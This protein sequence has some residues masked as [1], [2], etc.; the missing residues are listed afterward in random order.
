M[1]Q[2]IFIMGTLCLF[3]QAK[4][5]S[6][7]QGHPLSIGDHVPN[8][9]FQNLIN[10][11]SKTVG[12]FDFK[13]KLLIIDFWAT[14]CSPCVAMIPKMDSL[15]EQFKDQIRFLSV[16]SQSDKEVRAFLERRKKFNL[17]AHENVQIV[18][19]TE[20]KKWFPHAT[21]PHYVW[22]NGEGIVSA[23]TGYEEVN[24]Q[25]IKN[26]LHQ[27]TSGLTVKK[28]VRAPYEA[29]LPLFLGG[30]GGTPN[31]LFYHSILTGYSET[32][33]AG[34]YTPKPDSSKTIR[35]RAINLQFI[36]LWRLAMRGIGRFNPNRVEVR[37]K[38][39]LQLVYNFKGSDIEWYRA[40][41]YC[42]DLVLPQNMA[43]N[44]YAF[45]RT[46]LERLFPRYIVKI[47]Q[48]TRKYLALQRT[49]ELDKVRSAGAPQVWKQDMYGLTMHYQNWL[50][51]YWTLDDYYFQASPLPIIDE[52]GLK[53]AIDIELTAKM[54]DR[55]SLNE[56]LLKYDLRL[57][58][59]TGPIDIMVVEDRPV[60][61]NNNL[62]H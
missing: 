29:D 54:T 42:Y 33:P 28:D 38:D 62:I 8:I 32:I 12:I 6:K 27:N 24:E 40:H 39:S 61:A 3:F 26:A 25:N 53:G 9:R 45:F 15:Q 36:D 20:L 18:N 55:A 16:T 13:G 50:M 57:V 30:N 17:L 19:D 47:E 22:I 5:Q 10:S 56:A 7:F 31:N 11:K 21:L 34:T 60:V 14:W 49:S 48:Q 51:F 37:S 43:S 46:E 2:K 35:I 4:A 58:E 1:K 44:G 41:S 52:T 23:I 59:K